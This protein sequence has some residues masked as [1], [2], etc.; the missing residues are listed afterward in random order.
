MKLTLDL[1][2][3]REYCRTNTWPRL[4]QWHHWIYTRHQVAQ[5]CVKKIGGRYMIDLAAFQDYIQ[6]ATF[7][8]NRT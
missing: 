7:D 3:L 2:P 6:R 8:G 1:V 4:P 5:S